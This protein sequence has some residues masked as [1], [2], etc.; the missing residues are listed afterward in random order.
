MGTVY[1]FNESRSISDGTSPSNDEYMHSANEP[2]AL[3]EM[4]NEVQELLREYDEHQNSDTSRKSDDTES[5]SEVTMDQIDK[6]LSGI[7]DR[8]DK[9]VE[10]MEKETDRRSDEF[11]KEIALRDD[12]VRRELDLR[13]EA[14]TSEQ[15]IRDKAWQ[16]HFNGFLATQAERD[17]RLD[18]SIAG[19]RSDISNLGSLKLNIWGAMLT[20]VGIGIAVAALSVTF[21]QT[22]K[23]D[24]PATEVVQ[25]STPKP[26]QPTNTEK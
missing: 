3:R 1:R 21:Y 25:P 10:R 24:K 8:M 4:R 20:A 12:T 22:G 17:K 6:K 16:E 2:D 26:A 5:M 19:I 9:R 18:E 14:F 11:R 15:A 13:R 23:A 7:E